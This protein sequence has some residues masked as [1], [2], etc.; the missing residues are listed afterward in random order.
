MNMVV[1]EA[2]RDDSLSMAQAA[3]GLVQADAESAAKLA[4]RALRLARRRHDPEAKVAALHALGFAQ[5]EL[6]D[7]AA[8]RTL[9]AAVRIGDRYGLERR[10]ALARRTLAGCLADAGAIGPALR[11]I[12]TARASLDAHELA[13]SEVFRIGLLLLAGRSDSLASSN[14][15]L[16]ILRRE[17]DLIWEARLLKNRGILFRER[18]DA[19]AA[20]WDLTRARD[21]YSSLDATE[22][23]LGAD[24]Q[25]ALVALTR[26]DLPSCLARLDAIN[27]SDLPPKKNAELELLRAQ[28]LASGRL[29]SEALLALERAQAIWQRARVDDPAG[30]LQAVR[31]TLMAGDPG[32]ALELA[33]RAQRSFATN[34]RHIHRA[35][36]T[37]LSLAASIAAGTVRPAGLEAGRQA[38]ET[39]IAG[40]WRE[41]GV[42]VRLVVARAA[43]EV[44]SLRAARRELAGCSSLRRRG[45]V[46]DRVELRLV[47]ALLRL[48]DADRAG[49]QRAARDGLRLLDEYRAALGA[50][51]LRATASEIGVE[52]ARLGLRVALAGEDTKALLIWAERLRGS[53]LRLSPVTPPNVPLLRE[54]ATELRRVSAKVRRAQRGGR[55]TA[56]LLA[57]QAALEA[58]VRRLSRHAAGRPGQLT[59]AP[60]A[61]EIARA[62]GDNA[63]VELVELDGE[64]TAVTLVQS[65]LARHQ[66]GPVAEIKE[67]L[68]W[69]RFALVRLVRS[70]VTPSQRSS[71]LAGAR[72][73]ADALSQRL[74]APLAEN[75]GSRPLVLSP[76]GSLHALPWAMLPG[77]R[78]RPLVV[79]PSVATWMALGAAQHHRRSKVALIAGPH[80]RHARSELAA[81]GALYRR[82]SVLTGRK[83]TVAGVMGALD[84]ATVAHLACHGIFRSDSPL[85]SSLELADGALNAYELQRLGRAPDLI[86]LSACDLA[87]S[88]TRP[89]D[90]LLGFAAALIG[91]GTRTIIASVVPVPD[92]AAK[93][94]TV[95]LHHHLTQ[96]RPPSVALAKAHE[97]LGPRG[98]AT[99]GFVCLGTG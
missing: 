27:G 93:R 46:A 94:L 33:R 37:G 74:I 4:D 31:L 87:L 41:E 2:R 84:G 22:A 16:D 40:G 53:S 86:V 7:P 19:A 61:G 75:L 32:R 50:P 83:S 54:Q 25:L 39:L 88:D 79:A 97:A 67:Q 9:R 34:G 26:G 72:E 60:R 20:E 13:R 8:V 5:R 56:P 36:A 96:G 35:R 42:H 38:A 63:L 24:I 21:L 3:H 44:G 43:I 68:D 95:A 71:L 57:R 82:A 76:T 48:A 64:L 69:L 12:E 30:K 18:G 55:P 49:A 65:Q 51:E 62:L 17:G 59:A 52:L 10:A 70:R 92:A 28:A 1:T 11:E 14:R 66:L 45:P 47:E 23:A 99:A 78:G 80:L 15:A 29:M 58:S 77:L 73:S 81:V 6:G 98:W 89:G 90:E 85:F 91:M